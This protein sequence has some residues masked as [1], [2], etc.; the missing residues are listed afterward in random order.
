MSANNIPSPPSYRFLV[1]DD[2]P[3]AA[4]AAAGIL[5]GAGHGVEIV[6]AAKGVVEHV[7]ATRPDC[8]LLD[9]M[10]PNVDGY[11]VCRAIRARP[12]LAATKIVVLSTKAYDYDQRRA[13]ELGADG[14][15]VKPVIAET[16]LREVA[17]LIADKIDVTYWGVRGTLPVPGPRS[18]RYGGNTSCVSLRFPSGAFFI[19]DAGTGIK[20]LSDRIM[21]EGRP[22][23][24][25]HIFISHPHWDHIN[26]LPFF[27]PLYVPGNEFEILG[28]PHGDTS[29][30]DL[31]S[32]QMDSIYFPVTISEFGARVYF[33]DLSEGTTEVEGIT[34]RTKL[35]THPGVCLGYRVEY[36]GRAFCY[37]T[38]NELYPKGHAN[39]DPRYREEL[40]AWLG[41]AEILVTD[42]CYTDEE[43]KK[44][45]GWGHSSVS[46]VADLAAAAKVKTLHLFHHDP[47]QADDD[48]DAKLGHARKRLNELGSSVQVLAP[49]EGQTYQV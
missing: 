48:I 45:H 37:V 21:A 40:A 16:L 36:R 25:A 44:K 10:M 11:E 31:V 14:Y 42:T 23:M 2:D 1:V 8:V 18:M 20:A 27:A 29:V 38:D 13:R 41:G 47:D 5:K 33:R 35:L 7:G 15:L 17:R 32:H 22:R 24:R 28:A 30:R 43:Y 9:L 26:A 49:A 6:T 3:I 12:E 46:E 34:V 39:H 19:F 4:A